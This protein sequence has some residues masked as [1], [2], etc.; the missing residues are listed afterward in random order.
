MK[1]CIFVFFI[2]NMI[3]C[4]A[5]VNL[6]DGELFAT[7]GALSR[8]LPKLVFI[9]HDGYTGV[10]RGPDFWPGKREKIVPIQRLYRNFTCFNTI[11]GV[12]NSYSGDFGPMFY[13]KCPKFGSFGRQD[14]ILV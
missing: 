12:L 5:G 14:G 3:E 11:F 8:L 4:Q 10:R 2:V 9:C 13:H 6:P 1:L 7:G